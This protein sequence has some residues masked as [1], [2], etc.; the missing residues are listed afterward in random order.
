MGKV[1]QEDIK[2]I[3]RE[4]LKRYPDR[5]TNDFDANKKLVMTLTNVSSTKIRNKIAGYVTS[6]RKMMKG[7]ETEAIKKEE[8][9]LA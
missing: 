6:L 7:V 1:R 9:L 4:L 3:A 5:F 8:D 2:R